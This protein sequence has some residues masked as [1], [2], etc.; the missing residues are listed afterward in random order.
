MQALA[1][2]GDVKLV[3]MA[4]AFSSRLEGAHAAIAK[5]HGERVDVPAERR[6]VGFVHQRPSTRTWT[7]S[8][9][10][11]RAASH[12]EYAVSKD[13]HVF[14]EK[15]VATDAPGVR[16]VLAAAAESRRK[17]LKVGVGLG[18]TMTLATKRRFGV[19]RRAR[20]ATSSFCAA[21][22]T[23]AASG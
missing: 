11:P 21:T 2:E 5:R 15:P 9:W 20:S 1:T 16:T 22:G 7:W 19:F 18:A 3:A 8:C 14:M 13:R 17:G 6:H 10:R 23:R 12:F 4:D